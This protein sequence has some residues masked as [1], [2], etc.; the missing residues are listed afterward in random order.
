[1]APCGATLEGMA[2]L[3]FVALVGCSGDSG[4]P[5]ADSPSVPTETGDPS[6]TGPTDTGTDQALALE[7]LLPDDPA[8][9]LVR[10]V[11]VGSEVPTFATLSID[12]GE[13]L[14]IIEFP[15]ARTAHDLPVLGLIPDQRHTLTVTLSDADGQSWTGSTTIDVP[16]PS[17]PLPEVR[18]HTN[19]LDETGWTLVGLAAPGEADLV[20]VF[21]AQGRPRFVREVV[22]DVKAARLSDDGVLSFKVG[23]GL[24]TMTLTGED[25]R[26]Y[27]A[28]PQGEAWIP[29]DPYPIHHDVF[30]RAD[31]TLLTLAK[32]NRSVPAL[33]TSYDLDDV[34]P[35][36]IVDDQIVH[37][38]TD[39]SVLAQ[40][41]VVD[42]LDPSRIGWDSLDPD[43]TGTTDWGHANAVSMP[44][45]Q[46]IVLSVRHQDTVL[47]FHPDTGEVQWLLANPYGWSA[48]HEAKRLQPVGPLRW[49]S[50]QHGAR[51]DG[52]VVTLFDNGNNARTTPYGG[53]EDPL[54]SFSRVVQYRIDPVAL[55][56][57][58]IFSFGITDGNRG[59]FASSMGDADVL[60]SGHL[61]ATFGTLTSEEDGQ[62]EGNGRGSSS[63]RLIEVDPSTGA[64]AW[65][66]GLFSVGAERP[67]GWRCDQADRLPSLYLG[68]ADERQGARATPRR[69]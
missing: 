16:R 37:L 22:D 36:T 11:V 63:V 15:D 28:E 30:R 57:E 59:L 26:V 39:G 41:S 24:T 14:R 53:D 58:E 21:D 9:H 7:V 62:N 40:W 18:L 54:G 52:D 49:P 32:L 65:D 4:T 33:P 45:D 51:L 12:D 48:A 31:G 29:M 23:Q 67:R 68:I 46:T 6:H 64:V 56:V 17:V 1:M 27:H 8:V 35:A 50:H 19:T 25:R 3:L 60:P 34:G 47:A 13:A 61:L 10:R 69:P 44:D 43:P 20:A 38:A 55:T 66:L 2:L 42:L 5:P